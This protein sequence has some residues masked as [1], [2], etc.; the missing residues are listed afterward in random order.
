LKNAGIAGLRIFLLGNNFLLWNKIVQDI[1][2]PNYPPDYPLTHSTS[3]GI[4]LDF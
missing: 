4:N 2:R 1:D 3:I